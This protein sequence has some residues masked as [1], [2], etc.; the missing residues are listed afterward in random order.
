MT[1]SIDHR[2]PIELSGYGPHSP[3]AALHESGS[4]RGLTCRAFAIA[5]PVTFDPNWSW[6]SDE[7]FGKIN[8]VHSPR[9]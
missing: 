7:P 3:F 4:Y 5:R 8:D 2:Y 1:K 6:R 9:T